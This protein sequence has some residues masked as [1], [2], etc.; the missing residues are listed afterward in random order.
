MSRLHLKLT[1]FD[2]RFNTP[3]LLPA[4]V[5]GAGLSMMTGCSQ[6]ADTAQDTAEMV[7]QK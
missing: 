7:H 5:F 3:R 6:P 4:L 1:A 2:Y